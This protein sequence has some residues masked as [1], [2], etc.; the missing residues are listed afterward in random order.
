MF[1]KIPVD[2]KRGDYQLHIQQ[3]GDGI[4]VGLPTKRHAVCDNVLRLAHRELASESSAS[5]V[6]VFPYKIQL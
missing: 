5:P 1:N 3:S 4:L 6:Y 2:P